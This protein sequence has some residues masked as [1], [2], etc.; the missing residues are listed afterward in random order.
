MNHALLLALVLLSLGAA[1]SAGAPKNSGAKP[2]REPAV[3]FLKDDYP[4]ALEEARARGVPIFIDAW[5]PW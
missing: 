4:K 1:P 5:A 3:P 2:A